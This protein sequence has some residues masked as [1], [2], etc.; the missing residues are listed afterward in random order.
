MVTSKRFIV[1]GHMRHGKDA[2]CEYIRDRFGLS[3]ISSSQFAC[4][5]FL[6]EDLKNKYN[7][8]T[9]EECFNDRVN[10]RELWYQAICDYNYPVKSKLGSELFKDYDIYCGIRDLEEFEAIMDE[11][12]CDLT[13]F[14]D[15]S[16]RKGLEGSESMKLAKEH[17]DIVID[18]NGSLADL[19]RR[20]DRLFKSLGYVPLI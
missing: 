8:V 9:K 6:F 11:G 19:H 18:N 17:A 15:A 10:H 13:I 2:A 4:D 7:Y 3:F 1:F 20:L 12:L 16:L 5:E 14:I